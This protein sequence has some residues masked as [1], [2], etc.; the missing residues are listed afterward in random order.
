MEQERIG[1]VAASKIAAVSASTI[2]RWLQ[3]GSLEG[4]KDSGE[5]TIDRPTLL[6]HLSTLQASRKGLPKRE[7]NLHGA[8]TGELEALKDSLQR[9]RRE[10]QDLKL[11]V[12]KL[13]DK[14]EART[15]EYEALLKLQGMGPLDKLTGAVKA[16]SKWGKQ[17]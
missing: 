2:R 3:T 10:V 11:Q 7:K 9:E 14:L 15:A 5:W 13:E 17:S 16:L 8:T 4:H 12:A 6:A 1:I